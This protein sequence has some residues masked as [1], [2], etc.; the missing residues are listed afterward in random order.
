VHVALY[1]V[2]LMSAAS[3][4]AT[5]ALSGALPAIVGGAGLPDLGAVLPRAVHGIA[6]RAMLGLLALHVGAALYHQFI[7]RDRL[8]ARMGVGGQV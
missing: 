5:I 2:V 1:V 7:R 6:A 8:I 3:G 4:I